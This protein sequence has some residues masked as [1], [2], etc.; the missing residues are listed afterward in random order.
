MDVYLKAEVG[1]I[2]FNEGPDRG[3]ADGDEYLDI[4]VDFRSKFKIG[5]VSFP[6]AVSLGFLY[7][8]DKVSYNYNSQWTIYAQFSL[9]IGGYSSTAAISE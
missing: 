1:G 7:S 5:G 8:T 6:L 4:S 9:G 2:L 3:D